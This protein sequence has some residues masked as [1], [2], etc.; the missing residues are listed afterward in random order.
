MTSFPRPAPVV[1]L[2]YQDRTTARLFNEGGGAWGQYATGDHAKAPS[3]PSSPTER[4]AS[5]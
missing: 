2:G 5:A 4:D 1:A 3:T